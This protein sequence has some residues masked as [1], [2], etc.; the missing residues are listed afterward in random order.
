V[1][2]AGIEAV[3]GPCFIAVEGAID[4]V[5][6]RPLTANP[7][8]RENAPVE[9]DLWQLGWKDGRSVLAIHGQAEARRW[10]GDAA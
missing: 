4:H 8:V 2:R 10:L 5:C 7:Y 6:G 3:A 1:T 9:Y